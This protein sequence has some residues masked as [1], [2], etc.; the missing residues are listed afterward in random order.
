LAKAKELVAYLLVFL[1]LLAMAAASGA[2]A[3]P[4]PVAESSAPNEQIVIT[5]TQRPVPALEV[6]ATVSVFSSDT[7]A[8]ANVT[9]VKQITALAPAI[10]VINS[11][12]ES[13]GQLIA[14]RG[15]T[16]SG[17]DVG[18]ES[19][20][21]VTIDGVP[22]LRPNLAIFDFQGVERV[23]FL[24]GPQGT[25]FGSNTTAGIINILTQPPGF[26]P[27][28]EV[29]ATLGEWQ[30]R[31]IRLSGGG[32]LVGTQLAGRVDAVIGAIDGYLRDSDTGRVYGDRRRQ[33]F[34]GQLL[35]T[36]SSQLDVRLIADYFHHGG[37]INAPVY[38]VVGPTGAII[39]E[40]TGLS[41][42]AYA[43]AADVTQIDDKSPRFEFSDSA[44]I[45]TESD[46][47]TGVGQLT[48]IAS[49]RSFAARRDY[50][51]DNSPADL[52]HDPRD[53]ERYYRGTVELRFRG[54]AGPVDY[55]FG[56]F[57]GRSLIVSRDSYTL[58]EDFDSYVNALAGGAIPLFTGLP[59][60]RNFPAGSGVFDVFRQRSTTYA[61]FTH[62]VVTLTERLS[63]TLGGRYTAESK[64]L[65]A[66][67]ATNN[68]GCAGALALHGRSLAGVPA[69]LQ[70]LICIPNLDPRYDG[71][72]AADRGE[73]NWSGTA[74]LT[75][76]IN[77]SVSAYASYSRGYK[78]GGFQMDRSGMNPISPSLS[79]LQFR[80]E[81]TDS[82]EAGLKEIASNGSWR[83]SQT[84]FLSTFYDHQFSYFTG[85]NR[86]TVN[87]PE[88]QT[89]GIEI[90]AG[91]QLLEFLDLSL[92]GIYQEAIFGDSGFPAALTQL[93][94]STAP[95][96]P[97]WIL[98]A[99]ASYR[100]ALDGLGVIGFADADVRWQAKANVGASAT[101]SP[102]FTQNPYAVI[103][104]R[105]GAEAP[106]RHWKIEVWAR[107]LFNQRAWSILNDTT[108]QPGSISGYV[109]DPRTAGVRLTLSW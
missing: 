44:G 105:I 31:E 88:L 76:L 33:E 84:A 57:A 75:E 64:S 37:T 58:G 13:F 95:I 66:D 8:A 78:A 12:G 103:G 93:Q 73:G 55:L 49:Y 11:I 10:N 77:Q 32:A 72:Y 46:W 86:R 97:R 41:L 35:W 42:V 50:D 26:T 68:P 106:A 15:V 96:A 109:I 28:F 43:K 1:S 83:A 98:T 23:E 40:L 62:H 65:A 19:A 79:Q 92:A 94:G 21:G 100:K 6:P 70:G 63:L 30:Q 60:G 107:N 29:S 45:S 89:K 16:T 25:L 59:A 90:E 85:L 81:T 67:I 36:P 24:R 74:G 80:E 34:R 52:A 99:A 47:R 82:F 71:S 38:H 87:V 104:A 51:V 4:L 7:L 2:R 20:A 61:L 18:L 5:A 102:N 56:V 14:V 101:P 3:Q 69:A 108:L 17:A 54:D 39:T 27:F 22:L 53:G 48:A 9:T 91:Y